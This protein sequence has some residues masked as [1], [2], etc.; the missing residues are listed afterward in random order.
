[1]LLTFSVLSPV[2]CYVLCGVY[3]E[4]SR[5]IDRECGYLAAASLLIYSVSGF[6][7]MGFS[8][9]FAAAV[10]FTFECFE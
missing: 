10:V 9:A 5:Y 3:A 1:M 4:R 6:E 7:F 8:P 2:I